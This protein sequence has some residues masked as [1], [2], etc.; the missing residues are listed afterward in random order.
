[1]L[2]LSPA[3]LVLEEQ[4]EVLRTRVMELALAWRAETG[5]GAAGREPA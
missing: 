4:R 5:S 1:M 3:S 2:L